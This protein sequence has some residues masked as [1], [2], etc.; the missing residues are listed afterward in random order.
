VP[1]GGSEIS[2]SKGC[3]GFA[4]FRI[5]SW[6]NIHPPNLNVITDHRLPKKTEKDTVKFK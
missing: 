4:G 2:G 5:G 6:K 1:L 3:A